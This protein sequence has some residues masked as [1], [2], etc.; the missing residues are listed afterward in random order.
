MIRQCFTKIKQQMFP[1][2]VDKLL[3]TQIQSL[4]YQITI[5]R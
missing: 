2:I 3:M 1:P 4:G 5:K